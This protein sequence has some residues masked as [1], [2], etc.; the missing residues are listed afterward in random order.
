LSP[1]WPGTC[2]P[3]GAGI[4]D[5]KVNADIKKAKLV[6]LSFATVDLGLEKVV[7]AHFKWQIAFDGGSVSLD[8]RVYVGITPSIA[9]YY[10][11]DVYVH[12]GGCVSGHNE[13]RV[14]HRV[15]FRPLPIVCDNSDF[16]MLRTGDKESRCFGYATFEIPPD[17]TVEGTRQYAIEALIDA[18]QSSQEVLESPPPA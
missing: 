9:N 16:D 14:V 8:A 4:G 10:I 1:D 17:G 15:D 3:G 18:H 5:E 2:L 12:D 13:T 6:D 11:C 7:D